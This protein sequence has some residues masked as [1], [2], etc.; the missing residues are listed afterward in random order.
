[1]IRGT[2]HHLWRAVDQDGEVVDVFLQARRDGRAAKRFFRRILKSHRNELRKIVTDRLGSY[3]VDHRELLPD[4]IHDTSRY[5]NKRAELS[6]QPTPGERAG[7]ASIHIDAASPAIPGCPFGCLHPVQPGPALDVGRA[8]SPVQTTRLCV[9]GV[10][11]RNVIA[12]FPGVRTGSI[13]NLSVPCRDGLLSKAHQKTHQ[14]MYD[15]DAFLL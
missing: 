7:Y 5:A 9:L 15:M 3:G 14:M 11:D 2:Q 1:M 12:I 13:V 6:H 8:L 10:C 4:A